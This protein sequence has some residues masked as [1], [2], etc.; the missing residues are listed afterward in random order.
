MNRAL[1]SRREAGR[2]MRR[3]LIVIVLALAAGLLAVGAAAAVRAGH[4]HMERRGKVRDAKPGAGFFRSRCEYSHTAADDPIVMPGMEG[5]SMVHDFFGN[6]STVASSTAA[7][8]RASTKTTCLAPADTSAYWVPSL[9]QNGVRVTP[10]L[11]LI[12]YRRSGRA[13][14]QIATIPAGLQMIA[15]NAVATKPQSTSVAYWNCGANAGV[16]DSALPPASCPSGTQLV[17]SLVFPDC[18]DGHTLAGAGQHNVVYA[19]RGACPAGYPVAIPQLIVHVHYPISSGAGLTLS[20]SPTMNTMPGSIDTTHADFVNAWEPA[21]LSRLV[22][23]CDEGAKK[24]GTVGALNAPLGITAQ[25]LAR[26]RARRAE[27]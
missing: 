14:A 4:S 10:R 20:M 13:H 25:E 3:G 21:V 8:L 7:D 23:R 17:L 19:V 27:G 18:W 11:A 16:E 12:Y 15:G 5:K 22:A 1:T 9:Y 26:E 24:C 2:R 6:A